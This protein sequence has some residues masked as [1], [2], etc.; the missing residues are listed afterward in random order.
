MPINIEYEADYYAKRVADAAAIAAA[1]HRPDVR[2]ALARIPDANTVN[3]FADDG[4][5]TLTAFVSLPEDP[6]VADIATLC[7]GEHYHVDERQELLHVPGA[8]RVLVNITG[9]AKLSRDERK[10]LRDIGKL[11]T[12]RE[13]RT[14]LA[15]AA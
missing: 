6:M 11:K 10:L 7:D 2:E 9:R 15:C 4:A 14:Y 3:A 8:V 13:S 5:V 1:I 12:T